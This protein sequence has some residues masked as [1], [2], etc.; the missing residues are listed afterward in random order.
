VIEMLLIRDHTRMKHDANT[1]Y[2]STH[3]Q[4]FRLLPAAHP[5][6][7]AAFLDASASEEHDPAEATVQAVEP[8]GQKPETPTDQA[9]DPAAES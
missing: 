3:E 2:Y 1:P 6:E 4:Q 5:E 7:W 8:S 9:A